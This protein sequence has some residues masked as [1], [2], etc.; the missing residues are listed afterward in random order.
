[1]K[2]NAKNKIPAVKPVVKV[3][4]SEKNKIIRIALIAVLIAV[5]IGLIALSVSSFFGKDK[6]F[7]EIKAEDSEFGDLFSL[8][9]DLGASGA[10][11]SAEHR[12]VKGVY[13]KALGKFCKLLSSSTEYPGVKNIYYINSNTGKDIAIDPFLYEALSKMTEDGSSLLYLGPILERYAEVFACDSDAYAEHL[14]PTK[15]EVSRNLCLKAL[16]YS[17]DRSAVTLHLLGENT[18]RL[19]VSEEYA[20]FAAENGITRFIDL[21]VFE[22]AFVVDAISE[23]LIAEGMTLCSISSFD[24]YSRNL[25]ER[26]KEYGFT[27]NAKY[28]DTVYPV[29]SASYRGKMTVI[30]F[31]AYPTSRLDRLVSY[32]YSDGTSAHRFIDLESGICKSSIPELVAVS[33]DSGCASVALEA[34]EI[35]VGGK[36]IEES[37]SGVAVVWLD[38][39]TVKSTARGLMLHSPYAD[40]EISFEIAD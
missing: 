24:G 4:L 27:V 22:N 8:Y 12:R 23:A 36:T 15:N 30:S 18:V 7:T 35:Y 3:E 31:R 21:G 10:S 37:T 39:R 28:G 26:E 32:F 5:G 16:E 9:Y 20:K 13:T 38:G 11:A 1:M 14:D 40:N 17:K 2:K 29:C 6:G 33:D 25:D 34:Y 19:D